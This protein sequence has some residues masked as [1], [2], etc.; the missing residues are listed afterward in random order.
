M[1]QR[2]IPALREPEVTASLEKVTKKTAIGP[3]SSPLIVEKSDANRARL[4]S[5]HPTLLI[6]LGYILGAELP[7]GSECSHSRLRHVIQAHLEVPLPIIA[8]I[9]TPVIVD[10]QR[11]K[12]HELPPALAAAGAFLGRWPVALAALG[13]VSQNPKAG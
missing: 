2:R 8:G 9:R 7:L 4:R 12:R 10:P 13:V 1:V 6:C 5:I 11:G 3:P